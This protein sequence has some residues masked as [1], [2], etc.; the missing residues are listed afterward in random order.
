[1]SFGGCIELLKTVDADISV[2]RDLVMSWEF[3]RRFMT[4][5]TRITSAMFKIRC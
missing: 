3:H 5:I 1:M 2:L 4:I